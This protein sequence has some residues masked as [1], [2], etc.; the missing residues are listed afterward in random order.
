MGLIIMSSSIAYMVL[1]GRHLLPSARSDQDEDLIE[2][3]Q[4]ARLRDRA[5]G[6]PGIIPNRADSWWSPAWVQEHGLNMVGIVREERFALGIMR[7]E[8]IRSGDLLLV[9]GS[10]DK[11]LSPEDSLGMSHQA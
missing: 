3:Y 2:E 1:I 6:A 10:L 11:M 9:T 4:S 8:H 7:G 5:E